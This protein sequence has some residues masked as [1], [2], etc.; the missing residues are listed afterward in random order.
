LIE[1]DGGVF[2][3]T[4]QRADCLINP[5]RYGREE[6]ASG[7][8]DLM[9]TIKPQDV[10]DVFEIRAEQSHFLTDAYS[11]YYDIFA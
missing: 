7:R 3:D 11:D 2:K 6:V 9:V 4:A 10:K 5:G 1:G 8:D